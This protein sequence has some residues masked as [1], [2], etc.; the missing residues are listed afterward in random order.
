MKIHLMEIVKPDSI[1]ISIF[2]PAEPFLNLNECGKKT[3]LKILN[4]QNFNLF[5]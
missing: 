4:E 2:V 5:R 1:E 3:N